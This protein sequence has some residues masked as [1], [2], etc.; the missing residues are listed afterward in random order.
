MSLTGSGPAGPA[1]GRRPHRRPARRD[2]RRLRGAGGTARARAHRAGPGGAQQPAGRRSSA[3]T[4]SRAPAPPS[5][6]DPAGPGQPPPLDRPLRAVRL[7]GRAR[8]DHCRQSRS[9]GGPSPRFGL[10]AAG[11]GSPPTRSG[12]G[13][14][15]LYRR[16]SSTPSPQH[17]PAE[18]LDMLNQAGIPAGKVRTLDEV[19][20][21]TRSPSQG[22]MV[23]VEHPVLGHG[24]LPGPPLRFFAPATV[25]GNHPG[26][27]DRPAAAGRRRRGDPGLA[28]RPGWPV[29]AGPWRR[30][31]RPA[32]LDAAGC[33]RRCSTPVRSSAGIPPRCSRPP[34]ARVPGRAGGRPPPRAVPTNPSSP[35]EVSSAAAESRSTSRVPLPRRID[36]A[37]GGPRGSPRRSERATTERLPLLAGPAS[38]GTRMQEGT[39]ASWAWSRSPTRSAGTRPPG[40]PDLVYL[41]HPTTGGVMASWGSLGHITVAEPGALL[42]FLGPRVYEALTAS[43]SPRASRSPKTST[44]TGSSTPWCP[45]TS[46]LRWWT[47]PC[48]CCAP[49]GG[50]TA[51]PAPRT[52]TAEPSTRDAWS[53]I[54]LSRNPRRPDLRWLL[55]A[56]ADVVCRERHRGGREGPGA[57]PGAGPLRRRV[58]ASCSATSA[59]ATPTPSPWG[60]GRCARRGAG[61]MLAL[62]LDLPLLTVIDTPGADLSREAEEGGMAGEIARSL[63]G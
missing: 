9:S 14:A 26:S 42:G 6:R 12:C 2:V 62:D 7:P 5:P 8:A 33:S 16:A 34:P 11:P 43:R 4:P 1:A 18:L 29:S 3:S 27:H 40:L 44:G 55:A 60:R 15:P 45:R 52:L 23:E 46:W 48:R 41:R 17:G 51:P 56:G 49:D 28:G 57:D 32:R 13:T 24:E 38:G 37:G 21:G 36:R 19:Y 22:L 31:A 10:D 63:H 61:M 20:A 25:R 50:D 53:S 58:R 39:P 30:A 35:A 59:P 47:G 54:E